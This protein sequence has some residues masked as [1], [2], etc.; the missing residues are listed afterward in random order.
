LLQ[1]GMFA[2]P[3]AYATQ[4]VVP[5]RWL[6]LYEFNP[7]VACLEGLRWSLFPGAAMPTAAMLWKALLISL[8]LFM[9]GSM[10]FARIE[11]T[12]VDRV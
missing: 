6:W 1:L 4:S 10:F 3:V 5:Q 11:R 12:I 9:T 2:S 7:L 8:V